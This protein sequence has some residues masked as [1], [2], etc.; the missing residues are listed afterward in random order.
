MLDRVDEL[1]R[2]LSKH[3]DQLADPERVE[4][5]RELEQLRKQLDENT[6]VVKLQAVTGRAYAEALAA[7]AME[8]DAQHPEGTD[9]FNVVKLLAPE[10]TVEV[11]WK[12]GEAADFTPD[13][14]WP[15]LMDSMSDFQCAELLRTVVGLGRETGAGPKAVFARAS[16]ILR[17]SAKN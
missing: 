10:A 11:R 8:K 4:A 6:L 3:S 1:S 12:T 9:W 5:A 14:D 13:M 7:S 16:S 15:A 2:K 17:N